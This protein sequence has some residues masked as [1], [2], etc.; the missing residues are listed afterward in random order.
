[1]NTF[2][3]NLQPYSATELVEAIPQK[4]PFRFI[5]KILSVDE[6]CI[7]GIYT[8]KP[9]EFFYQ[10]HFPS[11]PLT[12]GVILLE[13]MAQVGLVAFGLYFLSKEMARNEVMNLVTLFT[14][15]NV[16]FLSPIKPT[17]TITIHAEKTLWRRK[18]LKSHAKAH[19]ADGTLVGIA[20]LGG[21]GVRNL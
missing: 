10:G 15:A 1:M 21:I 18:K 8:F 7:E 3:E 4:P 9:T 6:N 17:D 20:E 11:N 2:I 19:K 14:E 12:P 5:D 13:S 16:E